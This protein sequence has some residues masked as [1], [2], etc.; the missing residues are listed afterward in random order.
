MSNFLS[1]QNRQ[2]FRLRKGFFFLSP[3]GFS[4]GLLMLF[5]S[6]E[7]TDI[8]LC[9]FDGPEV[10]SDYFCSGS[11]SPFGCFPASLIEFSHHQKMLTALKAQFEFGQFPSGHDVDQT[12]RT[13]AVRVTP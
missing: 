13:S 5:S 11:I 7:K 1:V 8:G 2:T 9:F 10:C 6:L 4:A 3:A 12:P